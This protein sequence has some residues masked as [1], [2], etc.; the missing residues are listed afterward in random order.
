MNLRRTS[1]HFQRWRVRSIRNSRHQMKLA[2]ALNWFFA[3]AC[4]K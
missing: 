2:S 4:R 1:F 3:T